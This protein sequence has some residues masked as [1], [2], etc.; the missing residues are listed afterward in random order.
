MSVYRFGLLI[1]VFA[2]AGSMAAA[3]QIYH[4]R[5]YQSAVDGRPDDLILL[6][7]F[8]FAVDDVVVYQVVAD[9]TIDPQPPA[10]IGAAPDAYVG[11]ATIVSTSN[12]PYALTIRLPSVMVE[13]QSYALWVRNARNEWSDPILINDARPLWMSPAFVYSTQMPASL[14]RELKIVGR[15]LQPG[16]TQSTLVRLLGPRGITGP[17]AAEPEATSTMRQHVVRIPLPVRLAAGSYRVEVSR[18]GVSWVRLADQTLEVLEDRPEPRRFDVSDSRFGTCHPDD[19]ADDTR[20]I[21]RAI[22]AA[23]DAGGGTVY[24]GRG[25]WDLI[26]AGQSG[27]TPGDGLV[28]PPGVGLSGAGSD[29][30][31]L[32]RHAEWTS[33]TANAAFTLAGS[34]RVSGFTFID[35]QAYEANDVAGPFLKLGRTYGRVKA[36]LGGTARPPVV[37]NV[38]IT[39]NVFDKPFIAIAGG[40]LPIKRLFI[41]Y[42]TFGA[43]HSAL[44]LT[45]DKYNTTYLYRFDDTVI[46]SNLFKPGSQ[47]DLVRKTGAIAS[48][49]GAGRRSDF[50]GNT[51]DGTA[52]DYLYSPQ[53]A[54]GWRAAFFWSTNDSVEGLLVSE[55]TA[56]CTGDKIGDGEAFAFDNNT[57]TFALAS[58]AAVTQSSADAVSVSVPLASRQH[59]RDIPV[60]SYYIGHW[61]QVVSG[62]GLG[63]ARKITGYRTDAAGT[64][65][66]TVAPNWDV[67]PAPVR[68]RITVGREFWQVYVLDNHVDNRRPL[69]RKSNRTRQVAGSIV[70]WAQSADTI[71]AGN[72][73][74]DSDG[75]FVQQAYVVPEHPCANCTMQGYFQSF[76]AIHDNTIDGEYDWDSDCSASGIALG[77]A[78][79]PWEKSAP[80]TVGFGVSISHNTIRHADAQRSGAI[81]QLDSWYAGPEP[82]RWPLSDNAIIQHNAISDIQ[83]SPARAGCG[84]AHAR[85]AIGFPD[86]PVAWRTVLYANSCRNVRRA[87][88]AGGV[89]VTKV[90]PSPVADSCDCP[91]AGTDIKQD[92]E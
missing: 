81:A 71:I 1:L 26:D 80:P 86:P 48:E 3:P 79:A 51:A 7:G 85:V 37:E 54:R 42:N 61:I 19:G 70:M 24:F 22:A 87:L 50:S 43:Y 65:R 32:R 58:A 28:V 64:T 55:N 52:T 47:L 23:A 56:T 83:G 16:A 77:I 21:V 76:L 74:Y 62:P 39:H 66:F 91:I 25:T 72:H 6:A 88:A 73:Q 75:I 46:D 10:S 84:P 2:G 45:G 60:A 33:N 68:T 14:P 36:E 53:D 18:D 69:C 31:F 59:D 78:V 27:V 38:S 57:N 15:N 29:L 89:D 8:G 63:Q 41:T 44:D 92:G 82:H 4:Q 20:C 49:I 11:T 17:I 35:L 30:T 40:G 13:H 34:T 5:A 12:V 67:I 9:T 90:C